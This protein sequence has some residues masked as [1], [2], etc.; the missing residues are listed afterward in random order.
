MNATE[1]KAKESRLR[2]VGRALRH[3]NFR[4][5]FLSMLVSFTGRESRSRGGRDSHRRPRH[6]GGGWGLVLLGSIP[7]RCAIA[8]LAARSRPTLARPRG[9]GERAV[10]GCCH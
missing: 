9:H 5:Y 3:R 7:V 6:R 4:I 10:R 2:E 1:D 8:E